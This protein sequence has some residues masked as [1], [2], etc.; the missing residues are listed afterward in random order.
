[1]L[2]PPEIPKKE[3]KN[4]KE[5]DDD[6]KPEEAEEEGEEKEPLSHLNMIWDEMEV[7]NDD[8]D[9]MEDECVGHDYNIISKGTPKSN[10][11]S[12]TS[13]TIAKKNPTIVACTYKETSTD[14]YPEKKKENE[15]E[16]TPN[17]SPI[18]FDLTQNIMGDL[19]PDYDVVEDLKR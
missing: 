5:E 3:N 4:E 9:I 6:E 14:I 15:K 11:S 16:Q 1:M 2:I 7:D 8:D 18:N 17:K 12:S 19:N 13:T 10:D